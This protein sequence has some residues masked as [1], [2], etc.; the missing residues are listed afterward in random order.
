MFKNLYI[1][2][3]SQKFVSSKYFPTYRL[4]AN[5]FPDSECGVSMEDPFPDID[6]DEESNINNE[7]F[8]NGDHE[9]TCETIS[10]FK[11]TDVS[12]ILDW[13]FQLY[14]D[15]CRECTMP[16]FC[17]EDANS[18]NMVTFF[19]VRC[20][21]CGIIFSGRTIDP[22][23][24]E[25]FYKNIVYG[26]LISGQ[27]YQT[28][29]DFF[30]VLDHGMMG[31]K[32]FYAIESEMDD[33]ILKAAD[34]SMTRALASEREIAVGK[35]DVDKD[36]YALI[37]VESD[38]GYCKRSYGTQ[39]NAAS[40][41]G[42]T[43]GEASGKVVRHEV[44]NK[45]CSLCSKVIFL[46]YYS[47]IKFQLE[48][49]FQVAKTGIP[50]EHKCYKNYEGASTGMESVAIVKGFDE[51]LEFNVKMTR[52]ITDGDLKTFNKIKDNCSYSSQVQRHDCVNHAVK[53]T[54]KRLKQVI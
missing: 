12:Y 16:S 17:C 47:D 37:T 26:T 27:T 13:A 52:L 40:C 23:R 35:G 2:K 43:V 5:V 7:T 6:N 33:A 4:D 15:H 20:K 8:S 10:G 14:A 53:A 38:G 30:G 24:E 18:C 49:M 22:Q 9:E 41:T 19:S 48:V 50:I 21:T 1:H 51:T 39:Y 28:V 29:A 54:S 36:G 46:I 11:L 45:T 25:T 44:M 32:K 31:K 42:I 3:I 34:E